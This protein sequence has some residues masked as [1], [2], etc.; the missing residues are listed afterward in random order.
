MSKKIRMDAEKIFK[1]IIKTEYL[2]YIRVHEF[3]R[4][5]QKQK[6]KPQMKEENSCIV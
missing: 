6:S 4:I 2:N 5:W 3:A 1:K